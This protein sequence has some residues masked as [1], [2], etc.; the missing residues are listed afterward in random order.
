M[1]LDKFLEE[2]KGLIDKYYE[3]LK[4]N[5]RE[6]PDQINKFILDLARECGILCKNVGELNLILKEEAGKYLDVTKFRDSYGEYLNIVLGDIAF[7][8]KKQNTIFNYIIEYAVILLKNLTIKGYD[9]Y[10]TKGMTS[11]STWSKG[12]LIIHV[13]DYLYKQGE[14]IWNYLSTGNCEFGETYYK[15]CVVEWGELFKKLKDK[16]EFAKIFADQRMED[17][18]F[19]ELYHI[20]VRNVMGKN[21]FDINEEVAAEYTKFIHTPL[22]VGTFLTN[23]VRITRDKSSRPYK[24]G[25][26]IFE[27]FLQY[28]NEKKEKFPH[29]DT[30]GKTIEEKVKDFYKLKKEEIKEIAEHLF[31]KL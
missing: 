16:S 22:S 30:S 24:T 26:R 1:N 17:A 7:I 8:G 12:N 4:L 5:E 21:A 3:K 14:N 19:H 10:E 29:I 15:I 13:Y 2:L 11:Y 6:N 18:E 27:E 31:Y 9:F 25:I 20:L 23:F 28:I